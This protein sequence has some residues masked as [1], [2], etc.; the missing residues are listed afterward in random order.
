MPFWHIAHVKY[1]QAAIKNVAV[2][3]ADFAAWSTGRRFSAYS[4]AK[5]TT[6]CALK[7]PRMPVNKAPLGA[8]WPDDI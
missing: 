5:T 3:A 6:C 1:A 7:A 2:A 4:E 8:L